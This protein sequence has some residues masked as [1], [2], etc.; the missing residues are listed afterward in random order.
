MELVKLCLPRPSTCV[1]CGKT[2][3]G[4]GYYKVILGRYS[5]I[6]CTQCLED[7]EELIRNK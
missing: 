7:L 2:I 1:E 5:M 4:V 3:L 6:M